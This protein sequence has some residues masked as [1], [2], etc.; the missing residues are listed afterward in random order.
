MSVGTN[1]KRLRME[2]GMSQEE[3]ANAVHVS[4]SMIAQI[5]RGTKGL[6][7]ELAK[8][9]LEVLGASIEEIWGESG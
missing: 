5:E 7:I 8:E 1:L 3:L 2:K 4:Q 9:I 6:V